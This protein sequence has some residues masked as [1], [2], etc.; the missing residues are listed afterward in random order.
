MDRER[1]EREERRREEEEG[2]RLGEGGK[3]TRKRVF[4]QHGPMSKV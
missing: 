4:R 2:G 1:E 3:R